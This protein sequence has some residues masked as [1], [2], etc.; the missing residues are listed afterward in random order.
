MAK[1][2]QTP[3][4]FCKSKVEPLFSIVMLKNKYRITIG[5]NL[6]SSKEFNTIE[7]TE[8]YIESKPYEI[9]INSACL[10]ANIQ[11]EA[12]NEKETQSVEECNANA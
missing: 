4:Q 12:Q 2:K 10:F 8:K 5:N 11:T 1:K 7:E 6:I 3:I 9:L